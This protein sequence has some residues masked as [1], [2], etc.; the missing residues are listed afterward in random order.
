MRDRRQG[1]IISFGSIIGATLGAATLWRIFGPGNA[2]SSMTGAT[3]KFRPVDVPDIPFLIDIYAEFL[4]AFL[5]RLVVVSAAVIVATLIASRYRK[6]RIARPL[7][8]SRRG[9]L[10]GV[11]AFVALLA[12]W[13]WTVDVFF[14]GSDSMAPT[15]R[16]DDRIWVDASDRAIQRNDVIV[17]NSASVFVG[18]T[19]RVKR[20]IAVATILDADELF[21]VGDNDRASLDSRAV[22]PISIDQLVGTVRAVVWSPKG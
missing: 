13:T 4:R 19:Q 2:P 9:L 15:L 17:F 1:A 7:G 14:V 20:V 10:A 6:N 22:G 21:V 3:T 11:F 5:P 16:H 8:S 18:D 12:A